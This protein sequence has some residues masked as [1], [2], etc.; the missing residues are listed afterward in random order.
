MKRVVQEKKG[1]VGATRLQRRDETCGDRTVEQEITGLQERKVGGGLQRV[2][3]REKVLGT[4]RTLECRRRENNQK[5]RYP[6]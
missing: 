4:K 6:V 3:E 5:N 2:G 1:R